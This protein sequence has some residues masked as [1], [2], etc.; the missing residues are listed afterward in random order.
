MKTPVTW[1]VGRAARCT[2]Q[3]AFHRFGELSILDGW[4]SLSRIS[5]AYLAIRSR[6]GLSFG[7]ALFNL[8]AFLAPA[9]SRSAVALAPACSR[10]IRSRSSRSRLDTIFLGLC[11]QT[12]S[13][14]SLNR[15][16]FHCSCSNSSR[17]LRSRSASSACCL[18]TRSRSAFSAASRS[19]RSF[20]SRSSAIPSPR[21][22]LC[23]ASPS[24]RR[25]PSCSLRRVELG[26]LFSELHAPL[27]TVPLPLCLFL[28]RQPLPA[29]SLRRASASRS[30]RSFSSTSA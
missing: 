26:S 30:S 16:I 24:R 12:F 2:S 3:T 9:S 21:P 29:S 14:R 10:S 5:S 23:L 13:A 6:S 25:Q 18:A 11:G 7:V 1:K 4:Q 19:A 8:F 17:S 28:V 15:T 22:A 20:A 27:S